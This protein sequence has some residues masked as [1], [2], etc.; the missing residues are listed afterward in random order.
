MLSQE[1]TA[2]QW[3]NIAKELWDAGT[4]NILITGGEPMLREDFCDIY[5]KIYR[6]G[7][8]VTIYTNAMLVT[9]EVINTLRKYPPHRIGVT[10]YGA[11]NNTY[12]T[13]C[14]CE[15]GF[16][17][18][19]AGAKALATLPSVL[20]FRTTVV[21]DNYNEIDAI[22][23]IVKQEFNLPVT[24][25]YTVFKG[26]RGGCMPV[27]ECRLTPKQMVDITMNRTLN[28]VREL[29]PPEY[30]EKVYLKLADSKP[31]CATND[32]GYTLLGCSGGMDS[33]TITWDGKLLGCQMLGD[34]YTDVVKLGFSKAWEEWPYTV[35]LPQPNPICSACPHLHLCQICPGVCMAECGDLQGLPEYICQ[36]TKTMVSKNGDDLY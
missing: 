3:E 29:L 12:K 36:F 14:G 1:L 13:L 15:N 23:E 16:D 33:F 2:S 26:V 5:S 31:E 25:S 17:R 10:L 4:L 28:R 6:M 35:R 19:I 34:F 20:E 27:A 18:A 24:H 32:K 22:E 8:I 11:T 30:R 9:D 7:F 21:Q